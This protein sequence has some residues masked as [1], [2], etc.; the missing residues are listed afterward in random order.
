M[1]TLLAGC[2]LLILSA[3]APARGAVEVSWGPGPWY[4][5]C[6]WEAP[7]W[8]SEN[9][10]FVYGW[11]YI[12]RPTYTHLLAHPGEREGW[13]HRRRDWHPNDRPRYR[14]RDWEDY[15]KSHDADKHQHDKHY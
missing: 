7:C 2:L 1:K 8:Y 5:Y 10:V 11:G 14:G 15:K 13:S 6:T 3:C 12:N 9:S 4:S